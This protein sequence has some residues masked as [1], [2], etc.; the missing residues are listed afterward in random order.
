MSTSAPTTSAGDNN[1]GY[2]PYPSYN[3]T[4][5]NL[6]SF[7]NFVLM[8]NAGIP[9]VLSVMF[10]MSGLWVFALAFF[11]LSCVGDVIWFKY[12]MENDE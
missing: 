7:L 3:L 11:A 4:L 9:M 10:A 6:M 2:G 5:E 8:C 1:R 12:L